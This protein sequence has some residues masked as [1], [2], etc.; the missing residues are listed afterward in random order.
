MTLHCTA[1]DVKLCKQR[2]SRIVQF[3][4][5]RCWEKLVAKLLGTEMHSQGS[6]GML[7][8]LEF[9]YDDMEMVCKEY[10]FKESCHGTMDKATYYYHNSEKFSIKNICVKFPEKNFG[11]LQKFNLH[12]ITMYVENILCV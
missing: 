1:I 2:S 3:C 4:F 10:K 9:Y 11:A 7:T 8:R 12:S 5:T 6:V